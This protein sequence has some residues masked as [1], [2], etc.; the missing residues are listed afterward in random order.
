MKRSDNFQ[1][2]DELDI[3]QGIV[4]RFAQFA[5]NPLADACQEDVG[6]KIIRR[7]I[8]VWTKKILINHWD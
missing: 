5:A 6:E 2:F 3:M 8:L 4:S 1:D 7:N